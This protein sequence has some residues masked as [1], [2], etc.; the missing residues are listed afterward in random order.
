MTTLKTDFSDGDILY[1]GTT[2]DTDK[3]NGITAM[4]NSKADIF[5]IYSS[6]GYNTSAT[7][8]TSENSYEL[9]AI[10]SENLSNKNYVIISITGLWESSSR[11]TGEATNSIKIQT[12]EGG[13]SY[14]DS[15]SYTI[16]AKGS[17][18]GTP[19]SRNNYQSKT[20]NWI[21]TLTAGEKA[22][23]VQVKVFSK[24]Y[25]TSSGNDA[26]FTNIQTVVYTA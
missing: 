25:S 16:V 6:T 24:S 17:N 26:S 14:G 23:G 18:G 13:G 19:V 12:K 5:Q 15:L 1:A 2:S 3:L 10:T 21:H 11:N 9:S 20:F 8:T 4:I 7:N 22:N